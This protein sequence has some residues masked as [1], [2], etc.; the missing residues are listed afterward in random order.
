MAHSWCDVA[1]LVEPSQ[2]TLLLSAIDRP[3]LKPDAV[4]G[5][6]VKFR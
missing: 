4:T 3:E 2:A 6:Q 5:H 1:P